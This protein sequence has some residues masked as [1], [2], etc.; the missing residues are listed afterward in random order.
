MGLENC[1][2]AWCTPLEDMED[3][4]VD[5]NS[6]ITTDLETFHQHFSAVQFV[7]NFDESEKQHPTIEDDQSNSVRFF[8]TAICKVT[9]N[10]FEYI[11]AAKSCS[12]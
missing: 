5:S 8:L 7:L 4:I 11:V 1:S 10:N 3:Q 12:G 9:F 2:N 6:C